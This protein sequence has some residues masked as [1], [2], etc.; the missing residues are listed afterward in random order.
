MHYWL[1][2]VDPKIY[3]DKVGHP[4]TYHPEYFALIGG[5]RVATQPCT[6]NP[7]VIASCLSRLRRERFDS[8]AFY[9]TFPIDPAK[10]ISL[11]ASVTVVRAL[12][13]KQHHARRTVCA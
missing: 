10:T 3:F 8:N 6:T 9:A 7:E 5:E 11:F 12:D 1:A 2:A 4:E 13:P